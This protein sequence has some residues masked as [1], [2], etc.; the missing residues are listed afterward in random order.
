MS[1]ASQSEHC[2]RP[3]SLSLVVTDLVAL[4]GIFTFMSLLLHI[5]PF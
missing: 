2:R 5:G 4:I 3:F 1:G